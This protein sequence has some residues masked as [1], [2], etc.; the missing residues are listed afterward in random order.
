[1]SASNAAETA[2]L[3]LLLQNVAWANI[4]DSSGLQPSATDGS[5]YVGLHATDP[6]ETGSSE[7]SYTGYARAQVARGADHWDVEDGVGTNLDVVEFAECTAGSGTAAYA[8][9]W[10]AASGGTML[11]SGAMDASLAI[12][13]GITPRFPV[14][15]LEV[16]AD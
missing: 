13:A 15:T 6:G 5:L 9:L 3:Q 12:S 1:M 7:L 2:L 11:L 8:S 4:G 14:G 16:T 10:T